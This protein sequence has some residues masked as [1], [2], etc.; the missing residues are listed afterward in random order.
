MK[1]WN[2]F[3]VV[4]GLGLDMHLRLIAFTMIRRNHY[5][6][7]QVSCQLTVQ[8]VICLGVSQLSARGD[9]DG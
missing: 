5:N 2:D 9:T 6:D 1:S 8:E 3:V 4:V 7:Y